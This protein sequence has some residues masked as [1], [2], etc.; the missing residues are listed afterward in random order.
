MCKSSA[1]RG[2]PRKFGVS[3][4]CFTQGAFYGVD[5]VVAEGGGRGIHF[6]TCM[7]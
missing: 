5:A 1:T 2:L 4:G 3:W 6:D 7:L